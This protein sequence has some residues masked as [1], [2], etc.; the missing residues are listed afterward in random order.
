MVFALAMGAAGWAVLREAQ[1]VAI[2]VEELLSAN[3]KHKPQYI[4]TMNDPAA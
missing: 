2:A 1:D 4:Y 3:V